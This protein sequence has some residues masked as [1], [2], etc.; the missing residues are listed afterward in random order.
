MAS[1][2]APSN[3]PD[4]VDDNSDSS[5]HEEWQLLDDS[6][7]SDSDVDD[8]QL[9]S[10]HDLATAPLM[11]REAYLVTG[12]DGRGAAQYGVLG[13]VL[14]I[15]YKGQNE[16]INDQRLYLNTNAPFSAIVCGV[17]GSGKSH[18][19]STMLENMLISNFSPIGSLT[20]PLS[21]LVLHY[22]EGGANSLPNETA[23]LASSISSLV[24]GPSV[25]VYVSRASLHTMR[26]VYEP[27]GDKVTVEPLLFQ[28]SELDAAAILSMMAVGSAEGAPLYMQIILAILRELGEQFTFAA[29][30]AKLQVSKQKF[31]PAQLAGLEQ[32]LSLLTAFL[33]VEPTTKKKTVT[34]PSRF[35][36]GQLT[37]IDLSDP[38]L[39]TASACGLFEIVVRL[40]VR[41]DVGTG[42]VLVVDE[43]HKYLSCERSS[44][45]LT[46]ALLNLIRQ[47][48]H[49]AMRVIISTQE[50]TVV[51]PV[52]IDLC[53][54]V[55]LHRFSSPT[56]WQHLTQHVPTDFSHS[57][58]FDKV[59]KLQTGHAIVLA[60][61]GIGLFA[62]TENDKEKSTG[63]NNT[64]TLSRFG[65]RYL[66]MKTRKR[67]TADGGASILVVDS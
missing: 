22:G 9:V 45:G 36:P 58:A 8:Q 1:Y 25:R 44:T 6:E 10:R 60:P 28:N 59:V 31:N 13:K 17:Q 51:P 15:Q 55:I 21:G 26:T 37:I 54:V 27:L 40:F 49:L 63:Q 57:N 52:L 14:A 23:W 7:S 4:N 66:I 64:Q 65:R 43:A 24:T 38:F 48:R 16:K 62:E 11:T 47:Q 2:S 5:G 20:K 34:K 32:R 19:V 61:S 30:M 67:V 33:D 35:G 39:D 18:T 3:I 53:S 56:W 46:R 12:R 41:A 42:K 29:F 50:P